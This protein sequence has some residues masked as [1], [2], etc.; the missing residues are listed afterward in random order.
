M[1]TFQSRGGRVRDYRA[2]P[3]PAET[4][5]GFRRNIAFGR[6][7]IGNTKPDERRAI[8]RAYGVTP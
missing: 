7:P 4:Y 2:G 3:R 5:R 6:K 8:W 1:A